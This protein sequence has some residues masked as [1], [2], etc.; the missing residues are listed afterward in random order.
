[1]EMRQNMV[2]SVELLK[3]EK[4]GLRFSFDWGLELAN[5]CVCCAVRDSWFGV[6]EQQKGLGS[7]SRVREVEVDWLSTWFEMNCSW[8]V[9]RWTVELLLVETSWF[10]VSSDCSEFVFGWFVAKNSFEVL[11]LW[12][13]IAQVLLS[14]RG[15]FHLGVG[16]IGSCSS[17]QTLWSEISTGLLELDLRLGFGWVYAGRWLN[18]S[19]KV[20]YWC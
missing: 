20:S 15:T 16:V 13:L 8:L 3:S 11:A 10:I 7:L 5:G 12:S 14:R 17:Q 2:V 18:I 6:D 19:S 9:S 4:L 1:M